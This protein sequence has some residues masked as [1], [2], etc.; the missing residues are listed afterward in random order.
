M[1]SNYLQYNSINEIEENI[2][3]FKNRFY[4][5]MRIT[6]NIE[7]SYKA[8]V[9]LKVDFDYFC[10]ELMNENLYDREIINEKINETIKL[11]QNVAYHFQYSMDNE[12]NKEILINEKCYI[13]FLRNTGY[14]DKYD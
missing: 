6:D 8:F 14:N 11:I 4:N 9:A 7:K 5:Y 13:H 1:E 10:N 2:D 3:T 12:I